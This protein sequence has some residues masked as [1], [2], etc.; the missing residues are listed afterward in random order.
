MCNEGIAH[1]NLLLH[2]APVA[3]WM[4]D[5]KFIAR[6]AQDL[7]NIVKESIK[8]KGFNLEYAED[9]D[10]LMFYFIITKITS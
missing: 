9:E 8:A 10:K 5:W 3:D 4:C 2:K 7:E 6:S 1:K